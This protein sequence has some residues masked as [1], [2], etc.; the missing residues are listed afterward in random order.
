VEGTKREW[1]K[2]SRP[3][4]RDDKKGAP[5]ATHLRQECN[6]GL[7]GEL[8]DEGLLGC[9]LEEALHN[10]NRHVRIGALL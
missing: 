6:N 8:G 4:P 10:V 1:D 5:R 3:L 7:V 2:L 9:D